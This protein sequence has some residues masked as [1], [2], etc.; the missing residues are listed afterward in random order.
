MI[1][2]GAT[3]GRKAFEDLPEIVK[4]F[5][6]GVAPNIAGAAV[7]RQ[8]E[9]SPPWIHSCQWF[10]AYG[11]QSKRRVG[12]LWRGRNTDPGEGYHLPPEEL[13]RFKQFMVDLA[14]AWFE[15][16]E[17]DANLAEKCAVSF[18]VRSSPHS[19]SSNNGVSTLA[20]ETPVQLGILSRH[21][22]AFFAV[23][24]FHR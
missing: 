1:P 12:R 15:A 7:G 17:N 16:C 5:V 21:A 13:E 4:R 14:L 9:T 2:L 10:L 18:R 24:R 6:V 3:F 22:G 20:A 11:F 19:R 8:L 23:P